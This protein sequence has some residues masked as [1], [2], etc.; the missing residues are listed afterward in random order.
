MVKL[1]FKRICAGHYHAEHKGDEYRLFKAEEAVNGFEWQVQ[2]TDQVT[3]F[4]C[5]RTKAEALEEFNRV[6]KG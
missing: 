1:N 6:F 3:P 2:S 5:G 4:V